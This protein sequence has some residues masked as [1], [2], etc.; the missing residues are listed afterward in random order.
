MNRV[1]NFFRLIGFAAIFGLSNAAYAECLWQDPIS[2]PPGEVYV[3]PDGASDLSGQGNF[4]CADFIGSGGIGMT[5]V[6][7]VVF[8]NDDDEPDWTLLS[9]ARDGE[10]GFVTNTP[11]RIVMFPRG[12]GTRCDYSYLRENVVS[13]YGLNIG[14]NIDTKNSFACTDGLLNN[15]EGS[16]LPPPKIVTTTGDSCDVTLKTTVLDGSGTPVT[17]D[18]TDDFAFFTASRLVGTKLALCT[19]GGGQIVCGRGCHKFQ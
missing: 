5:K 2:L 7:G 11:D 17:T 12:Q 8:S 4:I 19:A 3:A 18:I 14:G 16:P 13:G 9:G 15:E 1:T 6:D 10:P